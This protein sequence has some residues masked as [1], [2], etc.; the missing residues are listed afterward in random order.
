MFWRRGGDSNPESLAAV[1][2]F[3]TGSFPFGHPSKKQSQVEKSKGPNDFLNKIILCANPVGKFPEN[4]RSN[5]RLRYIYAMLKRVIR[6]NKPLEMGSLLM[7][8]AFILTGCALP[9][10]PPIAVIKASPT[11]GAIPLTVHFDGTASTDPDGT[12]VNFAWDFGDRT[13]GTGESITHTYNESGI[14]NVILTVTDDDGAKDQDIVTIIAG[15]PPPKAVIEA[16][17]T[18]GWLPLTVT[19]DAT[20]SL[21]P[22]GLLKLENTI[23]RYE[24][25]FGDGAKAQ[26]VKVTHTYTD[27][28]VF[29]ATLSVTDD[30]G[31]TATDTVI[32]KVLFFSRATRFPVGGGPYSVA[33]GDFNGDRRADLAVAN[34]NNDSVALLINDVIRGFRLTANFAV[35]AGP[36]SVAVADFDGDGIADMAS[37]N[38][39]SDNVSILLGD[40]FGWAREA[41]SFPVG[42]WPSSIAAADFNR[43]GRQDLAVTNAGSDDVSIL[44]GD[45]T[46]D[47]SLLRIPVGLWPNSIAVGDFNQDGF[48]DLAT[49]NFFGNNVSILIGDGTGR[50]DPLGDFPVGA[51]PTAVAVGDFNGDGIRD[52]ATA[53]SESNTVSILLGIGTGRMRITRDFPCGGEP[54]ALAIGDFD[55]DGNQDIAVVNMAND[56]VSV[57]LGDGLGG[58]GPARSFAVEAAPIAI[59]VGD[60]DRN[61]YQDLVVANF[62]DDS[63]SILLNRLQRP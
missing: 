4:L 34:F 6:R 46:G 15:N 47:F 9:N 43:D 7:L 24:W 26:G 41:R 39:K 32:I 12:I 23:I 10:E 59:I 49:A 31:A 38:F 22:A 63:I 21:D 57:M 1:P 42:A 30:K 20:R 44:I 54:R 61:G 16:V 50:F 51:E 14:F 53:N 17:P 19:F 33:L 3:E 52:L 45:G 8:L 5:I 58:F 62:E 56:S 36:A 27:A 48:P 13:Y 35:G 55:R 37:A 40:G 25:D 28:G 29:I 11:S 60:I 2:V 18:S